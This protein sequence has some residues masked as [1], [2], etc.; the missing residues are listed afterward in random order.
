MR[1]LY[2]KL[3]IL[4]L[5]GVLVCPIVEA[6]GRNN[7][8][9]GEPA[10]THSSNNRGNNAGSRGHNAPA[11]NN[12]GKPDKNNNSRPGNN[13]SKPDKNH[14][15]G[16]RPGNNGHNNNRPGNNNYKPGHNDGYKPDKGHGP[17][18]EYSHIH[19]GCP[20]RP[21]MPPY[22]PFRR[23]A[24]PAYYTPVR[25]PLFGTMLGLTL[26]ATINI[27]LNSLLS[28]GYAVSAYGP[29]AIYLTNVSQLNLLWPNATLYYTDGLLGASEFVY[30]TPYFD[31]TRYNQAY[32]RLTNAYGVP[33]D[34]QMYAGGGLSAS[35]W[36]NNGQYVT[37]QYLPETAANGS[38][39]YYTLLSFGS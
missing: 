38:L 34:S 24:P 10:R 12:N 11:K 3:A 33:V 21:L 2:R 15:N 8:G 26:G 32:V 22:R 30:S 29:D 6:R 1:R 13:N 4:L 7:S 16:G 19:Y 9:G 25:V 31:Q 27:S 18:K 5:C 35:W 17:I 28:N 20:S 23:P 37:L 14:N 39:R 36:S